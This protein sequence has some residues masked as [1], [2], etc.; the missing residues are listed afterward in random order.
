MGK[1][2][3]GN[4]ELQRTIEAQ[5]VTIQKQAELIEAQGSVIKRSVEVLEELSLGARTMQDNFASILMNDVKSKAQK[6]CLDIARNS[7]DEMK[8]SV[9]KLLDKWAK[10]WATEFTQHW[11][12][13]FTEDWGPEFIK[14]L[15]KTETIRKLLQNATDDSLDLSM[16]T[17]QLCKDLLE[18]TAQCS[19]EGIP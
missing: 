9:M 13:D 12:K 2:S 14:E 4:Q 18:K 1:K 17:I 11:T 19:K 5:N 10:E 7:V 6:E 8:D 15:L 3:A 16:K